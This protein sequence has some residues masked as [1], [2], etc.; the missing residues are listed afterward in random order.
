M[1]DTCAT[2]NLVPSYVYELRETSG[3]NYYSDEVWENKPANE[4]VWF[5]FLCGNHSRS[6]P[7]T[8]PALH[9]TNLL[10]IETRIAGT[11]RSIS[12]TTNLKRQGVL[13]PPS[14]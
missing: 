5:D 13:L 6:A 12:G 4:K 11:Y 10:L 14:V 8:Q 9:L 2:A 3:K 7:L 1:H